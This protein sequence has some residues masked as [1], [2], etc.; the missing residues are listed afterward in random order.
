MDIIRP[1]LPFYG[2]MTSYIG[3]RKENQDTCGYSETERGLLVVVC[4]GMG[5]GP[6]GKTASRTAVEAIVN[7]VQNSCV[8]RPLSKEPAIV[9]V[10]NN[11]EGDSPEAV[12]D[13]IAEIS[14]NPADMPTTHAPLPAAPVAN[15]EILREAINAA[16]TALR[17]CIKVQPK[18]NGMGTTVTAMLINN[19]GASVAHVGDSRIY[20]LRHKKIVFRTGDHS[21]VGKMVRKGILTEEQARLS[22][23]SNIITRAL[24]IGD[25]VEVDTAT[26]S[27][28]AGDRFV[29]CTD[30]IWG[31]MP[32]PE[33]VKMFCQK[34]DIDT[35]A[36][37]LNNRVEEMGIEKGGHHDNFSM[38]MLLAVNEHDHNI[39]ETD[40]AESSKVTINHDKRKS[41]FSRLSSHVIAL[42]VVAII[43]VSAIIFLWKSPA[44]NNEEKEIQA[45][46]VVTDK[47][48]VE[49][50]EIGENI[51]A[52]VENPEADT[53]E[54]LKLESEASVS[55]QKSE[56][57]S[58]PTT[59][60]PKTDVPV[61]TKTEKTDAAL[62]TTAIA[63]KIERLKTTVDVLN[64]VKVKLEKLKG[65]ISNADKAKQDR[66]NI[67]IYFQKESKSALMKY[68]EDYE[69]DEKRKLFT[70]Y[71]NKKNLK[72]GLFDALNE[73]KLYDRKEVDWEAKF[74]PVY[75]NVHDLT[76]NLLSSFKEQLQKAELE[77][78]KIKE[79]S[80]KQKED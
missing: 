67:R 31:S 18:L 75:K 76:T 70:P 28:E 79:H 43:I 3:G 40:N 45:D 61:T 49:I 59:S 44:N 16:N 32:E 17:E 53:K 56:P 73:D 14:E 80:A 15:A 35:I 13:E 60:E 27:V 5:G 72:A 69:P 26:L 39:L 2:I 50:V 34:G 48:T 66:N 36:R 19:E 30:G 33:L 52:V 42:C 25:T 68:S 46:S 74:N 12:S 54:D 38:I 23:I 8:V 20:Q 51:E 10:E 64:E 47:D 37:K 71:K 11:A 29:L 24:G 55:S 78:K 63:K 22:A 6:G 41:V 4:D 7:Y 58:E 21:E 77:L 65:N 62:D 1:K 57:I 9:S